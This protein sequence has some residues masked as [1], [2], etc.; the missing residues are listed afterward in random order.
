MSKQIQPPSMA[1][2]R[3]VFESEPVRDVKRITKSTSV[4][5]TNVKSLKR[6]AYGEGGIEGSA[7]KLIEFLHINGYVS[8]VKEQAFYMHEIGGPKDH[9]PDVLVEL[10]ADKSLHIIQC[11]AKRFMTPEV[12]GNFQVEKDFV[13][14][15]GFKFHIWDDR[16]ILTNDMSNSVRVFERGLGLPISNELLEQIE[17]FSKGAPTFESLLKKY[18]MDNCQAALARGAFFL[19]LM[20]KID[21]KSTVTNH[22]SSS[23]YQH[24][25]EDR[26]VPTRWWDTLTS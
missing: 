14:A 8:R 11:K 25:F 9:V 19:N 17:T 5:P 22:F 18:G 12:M 15:K 26:T 4:V 13:L 16:T 20:K 2:R 24:L 7:L 10:A 3:E 23:Y 1:W 21:E 6:I